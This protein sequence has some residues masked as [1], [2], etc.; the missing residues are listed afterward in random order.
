MKR[1]LALLSLVALALVFAG[2]AD[3]QTK[4]QADLG[5]ITSDVNTVA[6]DVVTVGSTA[7]AVGGDVVTVGTDTVK[8][9]ANVVLATN[10]PL[11]AAAPSK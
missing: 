9:A 1:I 7:V 8:V 11:P 10:P 2:C 6:K 3:L 4:V 5:V